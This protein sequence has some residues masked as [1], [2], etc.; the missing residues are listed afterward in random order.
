MATKKSEKTG[1]S[2]EDAIKAHLDEVAAQDETFAKN[3]A[4]EHKSIKECCNYIIQEA[5]K[6][7]GSNGVAAIPDEEVY[8]MAIHYYDEDNIK[9]DVKDAVGAGVEV[10]QGTKENTETIKPAKK[11][12]KKAKKAEPV[13]VETEPEQEPETV[14]V[15][16]ESDDYELDIPLF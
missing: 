8:G 2:F 16:A 11:S 15:S 6:R 10:T 7:K 9:V 4:K 13:E 1:Y 12:R 14:E 3:Y 5:R